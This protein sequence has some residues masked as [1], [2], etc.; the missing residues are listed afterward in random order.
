MNQPPD[1]EPDRSR[2]SGRFAG[3]LSGLVVGGLWLRVVAADA[4]SWY[5]RRKGE[6]CV[7]PDA[8]YY[9]FL[10]GTVVRGE[11]YEVVDYG[12][13][14][15]FA[16]RTP[17]Y[18]LFLAACRWAFGDR[19]L[20]ARLVQAALGAG[21]VWLVHRLAREALPG[22]DRGAAPGRV[23]AVPMIAAAWAAADP[24]VAVNSAFL[25]SEA[26]FLPLMLLAQWGLAGLW[27]APGTATRRASVRALL[28]GAATGAAVLVRPSWALYTPLAL[29]VWVVA[30][31]AR[32]DRA[33]AA[34]AARGAALVAVGVAL[35][36][37]PWW[38]RNA[39]VYGRFVPTA[40]WAGAS[41]YDGLNPRA[42]GD[43]DMRFLADPAFWP[44]GEEAQDAA[45]R[46]QAW[47]FARS[48]PGRALALA[49]AKAAR[50]WS[51]WPNAAGFRHP[52]LS[53]FGAAV[54][55]P[56]F[57]LIALGAWDRR[58]DPRA[59]ALLGLPLLYTFAL[60]LVFV[61][62]MRYRVPAAV[63]ALGLAAVGLRR[64]VAS[65]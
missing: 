64:L 14:P 26:L 31:L 41:L 11:P 21:C 37:A 49:G 27:A 53:A 6:L 10:A 17:G 43:S 38:V 30:E 22:C 35:V 36:M 47:A 34:G 1:P 40:V 46:E 3:P 4:V 55:L 54:A 51:P 15:R 12:D 58:R 25:L 63:P 2:R 57:A 13:L 60:H 28:T 44:L 50:F 24:Y 19:T 32:G 62:S 8:D 5:A 23:W 39:R 56:Q 65:R 42:V 9:W 16:L 61:S 45:L 52:A 7:F 48:D 29:A 59:L 33:R 18:P 20:P